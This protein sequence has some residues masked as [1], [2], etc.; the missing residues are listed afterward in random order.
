MRAAAQ[1]SQLPLLPSCGY[2]SLKIGAQTVITR[3]DCIDLCGLDENEVAAISEHEH[4][5]EIV[6][7]ALANYLLHQPHGGEAIRRMIIDDIH[8]ALDEGRVA[9]A[10]E[11][12]A[13][14]EHFLREHPEGRVGLA[15][16]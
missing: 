16:D 8:K 12:F 3:Q 11:L 10:G 4:V 14:L 6:A 5:P 13:A 2:I 7:A 15:K 1:G 9:H